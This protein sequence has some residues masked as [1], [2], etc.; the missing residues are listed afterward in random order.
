MEPACVG[1]EGGC[2]NG[3]CLEKDGEPYGR[4]RETGSHGVDVD[5]VCDRNVVDVVV[6]VQETERV[7][8]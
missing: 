3:A 1:P 2:T 6:D 4:L 7:A 5:V 8:R